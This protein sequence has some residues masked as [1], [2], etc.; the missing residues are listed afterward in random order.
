MLIGGQRHGQQIGQTAVVG[1]QLADPLDE[2]GE[3]GPRVPMASACSAASAYW[4]I[5]STSAAATSWLRVGNR[6]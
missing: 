4:A 5:L 1:L 6:R 3:P 2:A